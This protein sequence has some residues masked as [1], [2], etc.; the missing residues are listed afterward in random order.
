MAWSLWV[1]LWLWEVLDFF[2]ASKAATRLGEY[3]VETLKVKEKT[4]GTHS[5]QSGPLQAIFCG[6]YSCGTTA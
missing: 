6:L 3:E 2:L 4:D 5:N 1:R